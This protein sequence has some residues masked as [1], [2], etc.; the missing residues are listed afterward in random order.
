MSFEANTPAAAWAGEK[1]RSSLW[2]LRLMR[3]I[4]LNAGRRRARGVLHPVTVCFPL[5]GGVVRP[6]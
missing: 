6:E 3:W 4:A 5:T 2:M 1:E